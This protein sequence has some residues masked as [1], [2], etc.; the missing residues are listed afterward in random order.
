MLTVLERLIQLTQEATMVFSI[1]LLALVGALVLAG[2][3]FLA[4]FLIR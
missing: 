3:I 1:S 4:F 2:A